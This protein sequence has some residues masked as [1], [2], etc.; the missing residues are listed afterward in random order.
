MASPIHALLLALGVFG[1][2]SAANGLTHGEPHPAPLPIMAVAVDEVV[3]APEQ[4]PLPSRIPVGHVIVEVVAPL[5][6]HTEVAN[7]TRLLGA[8]QTASNGNNNYP[9][10]ILELITL[11]EPAEAARV[12]EDRHSGCHQLRQDHQRDDRR[13]LHREMQGGSEGRSQTEVDF[14]SCTRG[15]GLNKGER[16]ARRTAADR[17][18]PN[19]ASLEESTRRI[20]RDHRG[21]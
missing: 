20:R 9:P 14:L 13:I 15:I 18:P 3:Q 17:Q 12:M 6:L 1:S 21:V 11:V 19:Q 8:R 2:V 5:P 10:T 4:P 7:V 16:E